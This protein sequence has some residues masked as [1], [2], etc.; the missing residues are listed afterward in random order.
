MDIIAVLI[1]LPVALPLSLLVCLIIALKMGRPFF[2]SQKRTGHHGRY[3]NIYKF[4]TMKLEKFDQEGRELSD[5]QRMTTFG[6]FL[7]QSSLD[8]LP[9]LFNVLK[10]DLSLVGPRPLLPEYD[11]LYNEKQKKR[12]DV[13]PGIT[14]LAQINGRNSLSWDEK[15]EQ[16]VYYV[17][18]WS[19]KLDFQILFKTALI[20][21]NRKGVDASNNVTMERFKGSRS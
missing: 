5:H 8:E 2:F 12:L 14:G 17:E 11:E 19:L 6:N 9:Q 3:F 10:G 18:H 4:R 16:D 7:R 1:L 13:M 21:L 15:F 20:V